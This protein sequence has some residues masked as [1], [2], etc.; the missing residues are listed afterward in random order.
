[1]EAMRAALL[2]LPLFLL[3]CLKDSPYNPPRRIY[4]PHEA[5]QRSHLADLDSIS[6][7]LVP[8]SDTNRFLE[9]WS[10]RTDSANHL[11]VHIASAGESF[12][13]VVHGFRDG[14]GLCRIETLR[15]EGSFLVRDQCGPAKGAAFPDSLLDFGDTL[16]QLSLRINGSGGGP[17]LLE[18]RPR[19]AWIRTLDDTLSLVAGRETALVSLRIDR[20]FL[21][22]GTHKGLVQLWGSAGLLDSIRIVAES[23]SI[24]I[25]PL[26]SLDFGP[27]STSRSIAVKR[28]FGVPG[29]VRL[30]TS[31]SWIAIPFLGTGGG[32]PGDFDTVGVDVVHAGLAPGRY[33]AVIRALDGNSVAMDSLPVRM[34]VGLPPGNIRGTVID[35][36]TGAPLADATLSLSLTMDGESHRIAHSDLRGRF[37]FGEVD[38]GFYYLTSRHPARFWT[39]QFVLLG[40]DGVDLTVPFLPAAEFQA[41]E[42]DWNPGAIG[43]VTLVDGALFATSR[44]SVAEMLA[45]PIRNPGGRRIFPLPSFTGNTAFGFAPFEM[46]AI[47]SLS[48]FI[49]LPADSAIIQVKDWFGASIRRQFTLPFQPFGICRFGH[50]LVTVGAQGNRLILG[51]LDLYNM[52]LLS[53]DTLPASVAGSALGWASG[54]NPDKGPRI[55]VSPGGKYCILA[56]GLAGAPDLAVTGSLEPGTVRKVELFPAGS[57]TLHDVVFQEFMLYVS[58]STGILKPKDLDIF[59]GSLVPFKPV[60]YVNRITFADRGRLEAYGFATTATDTVVVL[61][62]R[63]ERAAGRM[64]LPGGL[65]GKSVAADG[66]S[67][68]V[69][70]TDGRRIYMAD[71]Q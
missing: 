43:P 52:T 64:V 56:G 26:D 18:I 70:T 42:T 13:F 40:R 47:E 37:D 4:D 55:L 10:G 36:K 62:S 9:I 29:G 7:R 2:L 51:R 12:Y 30:Q 11:P 45:V 68:A 15:E 19:Q 41:V 65:P 28:P 49:S 23:K 58:S 39:M 3:S 48:V 21:A 67:G 57:G 66:K 27:S 31:A 14:M 32:P 17:G 1:M 59:G 44:G 5:I 22:P 53:M 71:F 46:L 50:E 25:F 38:S 60:G 63:L 34:E 20:S 8:V 24:R 69:V 61:H 6:I 33:T 16:V 35:A 54:G